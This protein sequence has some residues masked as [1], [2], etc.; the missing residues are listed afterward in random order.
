M[1]PDSVAGASEA[2]VKKNNR[3]FAIAALAVVLSAGVGT[4]WYLHNHLSPKRF[5]VVTPG[6]L[7]RCGDISPEELEAV[8]HTYG[9]RTVLSLLNPD[10]PKSAEERDA[11]RRLGLR[12]ENVPLSG[13]GASTPA[14][15]ERIKDILFDPDVGPLLVHCSAGT[16]RTGLT[17]GMYRIHRDG[18]TVER[19]LDEM[20]RYGFEDLPKHENLREAL[21]TE[22]RLAHPELAESASQPTRP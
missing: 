18:W 20:R 19:V 22:W 16:N 12:W 2:V 11:A 9:I 17:I 6:L 14:D 3:R 5:G 4:G 21:R 10:V 7:Y 13:D 1:I 15:R 8:T